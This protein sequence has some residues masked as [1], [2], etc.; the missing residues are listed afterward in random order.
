M[1]VSFLSQ[2]FLS[3]RRF[4]FRCELARRSADRRSFDTHVEEKENVFACEMEYTLKSFGHPTIHPESSCFADGTS[5]RTET[6]AVKHWRVCWCSTGP[7]G[8]HVSKSPLCVLR[9]GDA[10]CS[11]ADCRQDRNCPR[12]Q[13][14][15]LLQRIVNSSPARWVESRMPQ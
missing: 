3:S 12:V 8:S 7:S 11:C 9:A 5:F 6:C 10:L 1:G 4:A 13:G 15:D 2:L 14:Q